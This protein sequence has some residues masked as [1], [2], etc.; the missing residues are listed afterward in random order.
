MYEAEGARMAGGAKLATDHGAYTGPG[1]AAGYDKKG[2]STT[3]DVRTETDGAY[4]VGL[5]Y[6][7]GP[8]PFT[9]TKTVS[10]YVN[11]QKVKRTKLLSTGSWERWSTQTERLELRAGTNTITYSYDAED[12]GYVNLDM[13][14]VHPSGSKVRLFEGAD[15][16]N[17]QHQDGRP[18]KWPLVDEDAMEVCCGSIRTKESYQDFKLHVEFRVPELP[19]DVTGQ[20]RGNSGVFLQDRYEIQVLDSYGDTTPAKDE[21]GAIYGQKPAD[22]N[23]AKPPGTWQTYDITFRAARFD[24][25]GVKTENARVTVVWNG[26]KVQDDVE[27]TGATPYSASPEGP[28]AGPV[29][30]QDHGNAV[31]YRNISIQPL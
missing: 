23:A 6:S 2:A 5:R 4:D 22:V 11:G 31:R 24:A 10:V 7:N 15:R 13:I 25:N 17:F 9:G 21:A 3:F 20:A 14:G 30:L 8:Y 26:T 18:V 16:S 12:T 28:A 29:L 1:F 27:I 19:S